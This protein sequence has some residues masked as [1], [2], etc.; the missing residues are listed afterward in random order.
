MLLLLVNN[1][2]LAATFYRCPN[3]E[4]LNRYAFEIRD[5]AR[6][7]QIKAKIKSD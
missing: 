1:T 2:K 6:L 7:L 4:N 5:T 3:Y